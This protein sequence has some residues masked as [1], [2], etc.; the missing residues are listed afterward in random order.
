MKQLY[1]PQ[2][3]QRWKLRAR[4]SL[5]V[6]GLTLGIALVICI[7]LCCMVDTGNSDTLLAAVIA[8]STLAGW[9][10][11][12]TLWFIYAPARAEAEHVAGIVQGEPEEAQG[13]LTIGAQ[14]FRIPHSVT[15]YKAA[16]TDGTEQRTFNL[17]VRLAEEL[18]PSGT[19]VRILTVRKFITAYEVQDEEND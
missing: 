11:I 13:V 14:R 17:N 9:T 12:L 1:S 10:A 4:R 2:D 3:A 5:A 8:L 6:A 19:P 7:I 16:L 15:F 18:P